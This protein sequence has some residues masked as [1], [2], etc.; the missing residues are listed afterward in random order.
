MT[1]STFEGVGG[2]KMFTRSWQ[3]EGKTRVGVVISQGL[4]RIAGCSVLVRY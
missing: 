4:I 2:L 1:E 3:P